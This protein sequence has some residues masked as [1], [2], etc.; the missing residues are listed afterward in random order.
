ML[1]RPVVAPSGQQQ[2]P[3]GGNGGGGWVGVSVA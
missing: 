2:R 1:G 3:I